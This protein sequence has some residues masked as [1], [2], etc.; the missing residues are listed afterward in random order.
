MQ[1]NIIGEYKFMNYVG[2]VVGLVILAVILKSSNKHTKRSNKE[3]VGKIWDNIDNLRLYKLFKFLHQ[4]IV[5]LYVLLVLG[6]E[7]RLFGD[8]LFLK[9]FI[10]GEEILN[11]MYWVASWPS[12]LF[13]LIS[14]IIGSFC[15]TKI[16]G[17]IFGALFKKHCLKEDS[18]EE[19]KKGY[20][21]FKVR[22]LSEQQSSYLWSFLLAIIFILSLMILGY[23]VKLPVPETIKNGEVLAVWSVILFGRF[24]WF[25]TAGTIANLVSVFKDIGLAMQKMLTS[26]TY[27]YFAGL[28]MLGYLTSIFGGDFELFFE[29]LSITLLIGALGMLVLGVVLIGY[30][31]L[32]AK[33]ENTKIENAVKEK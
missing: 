5:V 13:V 17:F 26:K 2:V 24:I 22:K 28:L 1:I 32:K 27:L 23:I 8:L 10:F 20:K 15:I 6:F 16:F 21:K 18:K 14:M 31:I 12:G 4:S 19:Q 3:L 29:G 9:N 11:L 25:E 30:E 7:S 33:K